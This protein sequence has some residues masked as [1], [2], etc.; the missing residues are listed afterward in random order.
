MRSGKRRLRRV[1]GGI[2]GQVAQDA[3]DPAPIG[4]VTRALRGWIH[5]WFL[6][7]GAEKGPEPC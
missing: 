3:G 2:V 6:G 1:P 5:G 4:K 7:K